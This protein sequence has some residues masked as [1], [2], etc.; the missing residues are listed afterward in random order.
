MFRFISRVTTVGFGGVAAYAAYLATLADINRED[1][2]KAFP[3]HLCSPQQ[4]KASPRYSNLYSVTVPFP[5]VPKA[6]KEQ[7]MKVNESWLRSVFTSPLFETEAKILS[8]T[9][10]QGPNDVDRKTSNF[11]V[12]DT[13]AKE[14]QVAEKTSDQTL[15][16]IGL[17]APG[18]LGLYE[19]TCIER[20]EKNKCFKL[21]FGTVVDVTDEFDE[22]SFVNKTARIFHLGYSMALIDFARRKFIK[23]NQLVQ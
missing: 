10:G 23:E 11:D 17:R 22:N 13:F 14:F 19:G 20:D 8:L 5:S 12:G 18:W 9:I 16:K 2:Q 7:D 3:N 21:Y 4:L 6:C 15:V 1:S